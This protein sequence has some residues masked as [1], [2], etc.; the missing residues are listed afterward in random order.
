MS[1]IH[2]ALR[3]AATRHVASSSLSRFSKSR[4]PQRMTFS[5][6]SALDKAQI[7]TRVLDILKTF[8]KVHSEKV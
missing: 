5:A 3:R 4:I 2:L 6:A 1:F 7:E 8:E